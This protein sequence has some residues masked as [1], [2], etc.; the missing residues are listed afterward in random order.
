VL[1]LCGKAAASLDSERDTG[2]SAASTSWYGL[3]TRR[4]RPAQVLPPGRVT[5]SSPSSMPTRAAATAAH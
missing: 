3:G 5:T 4:K 1:L 2:A